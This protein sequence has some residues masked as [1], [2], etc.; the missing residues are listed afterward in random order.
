VKTLTGEVLTGSTVALFDGYALWS[1]VSAPAS[2]GGYDG[3]MPAYADLVSPP[4]G[5]GKIP[6]TPLRTATSD[7]SGRY[8][9]SNIPPGNSYVVLATR[10]GFRQNFTSSFTLPAGA[11]VTKDI[12]L[13]EVT[14]TLSQLNPAVEQVYNSAAGV[15]VR[16]SETMASL[17][18][19]LN[20]DAALQND[21][22]YNA[23]N[24]CADVLSKTAFVAGTASCGLSL[25]RS[26]RDWYGYLTWDT[27]VAD[28]LARV[29]SSDILK[30]GLMALST[31]LSMIGVNGLREFY[32][33]P[34]LGGLYTQM[35][36]EFAQMARNRSFPLTAQGYRST[37]QH[38]IF[39]DKMPVLKSEH[40]AAAAS[41]VLPSEFDVQQAEYVSRQIS[42]QLNTA[43]TLPLLLLV[44]AS[45]SE[46][47]LGLKLP[48]FQ[49]Q[50]VALSDV[51]RRL[52]GLKEVF[53][54]VKI[55]GDSLTI[56]GA[57][58]TL[59]GGG[60]ATLAGTGAVLS[61][62][63][64]VGDTVVTGAQTLTIDQMEN[65][66][67][68]AYFV[69]GID[70]SYSL[71]VF[72]DYASFLRKE[73]ANP[74]YLKTGA[75]FSADVSVDLNLKTADVLGT[76]YPL[77]FT[78]PTPGLDMATG[79]ATVRVRNTGSD[80]SEFRIV[81]VAH[82]SPLTV[83]SVPGLSQAP[84]LT[85]SATQPSAGGLTLSPGQQVD[86]SIPFAGH[87]RNFLSQFKPHY[88]T[89]DTYSGPFRVGRETRRFYVLGLGEN[90]N[91]L[92]STLNGDSNTAYTEQA[93]AGT[94][95]ADQYVAPAVTRDGRLSISDLLD[96]TPEADE[97]Q[98]FT[99]SAGQPSAD[100]SVDVAEGLFAAD[101]RVFAPEG[102]AIGI[103]VRAPDGRRLGYSSA[104][105]IKYS[106]LPGAVSDPG[107]VPAL[108]RLLRP[109][110]GRYS[111]NIR[112]LSPG[113]D[114]VPVSAFYEP[115]RVATTAIMARFPVPD[116]SGHRPRQRCD[117]HSLCVR[118]DRTAYSFRGR[119]GHG[120][121]SNGR[122]HTPA[123]ARERCRA[124]GRADP[125]G[126][127]PAPVVE[128][129]RPCRRKAR[130]VCRLPDVAEQSDWLHCPR[131]PGD[132]SGQDGAGYH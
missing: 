65:A 49:Q 97:L 124:D 61:F 47:T 7:A 62:G 96:Q 92:L 126:R 4:P 71:R 114:L 105:G 91:S 110:P 16:N 121:H 73:A 115:V 14:P 129:D 77:M 36:A 8:G 2:Q 83:G 128:G 22:F 102:Q 109:G 23:L 43:S 108:V 69:Y 95:S 85:S 116:P 48:T 53:T 50:Y 84:V 107:Q 35:T 111:I 94:E 27:T 51:Y 78:W 93:A 127:V 82:W 122:W 3:R 26:F 131:R 33:E 52:F 34:T 45:P 9:W 99:L 79:S 18:Q 70:N 103:L 64:G 39:A 101:L 58:L 5:S 37:R 113:P 28:P 41:T 86:L 117:G 118:S 21:Q 46:G 72:A 20:T 125:V 112:L 30:S 19:R 119:G 12:A 68:N 132:Y 74:R 17:T 75:A 60:G 40:Q 15:M 87:S 38:T 63:G 13:V 24:A 98:D 44:P 81:S 123:C 88:L 59:A 100:L 29:V 31:D 67:R 6:V 32:L 56:A 80:T 57:G 42:E 130:Q 54:T 106:E 90:I 25:F 55:V 10:A 11:S 120:E 1:V 89:V 66:F 76:R 104:D